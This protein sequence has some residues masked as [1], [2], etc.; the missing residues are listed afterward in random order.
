MKMSNLLVLLAVLCLFA[1]CKGSGSSSASDY[2]TSSADSASVD[3]VIT[4]TIG[5]KLVKTGEM[6]FKVKDVQQA[7]EKIGDLARNYKGFVVH[8]NMQSSIL[9]DEDMR[10][11]HIDSLKHVSAYTSTADI[12]VKVPSQNLEQFLKEVSHLGIYVNVRRM[13][14]EDKT[15][16]YLSTRLKRENRAEIDSKQDK[17]KPTIKE[18]DAMLKLK[19]D[20]VDQKISNTFLDESVKYSIVVLN[21][22]QSNTVVREMVAN[23]N[24]SAYQL[25]LLSRFWIAVT[26]GWEMFAVF[27]IGLV[28]LWVFILAGCGA[29]VGY[30]MYKRK[31]STITTAV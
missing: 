19:D 10:T 8:H 23:D 27:I 25:P 26:D 4:D 1:A 3:A 31:N 16:D 30:R 14:I 21:L 17:W 13:D 7:G 2:S 12:T 29:W 15:L 24:T 11:N 20:M 28:N 22:Y 5:K 18:A 9:H 6:R